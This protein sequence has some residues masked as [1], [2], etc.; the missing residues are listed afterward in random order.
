[1]YSITD[2]LRGNSISK[3]TFFQYLWGGGGHGRWFKWRKDD[4]FTFWRRSWGRPSCEYSSPPACASAWCTYEHVEMLHLARTQIILMGQLRNFPPLDIYFVASFV[5]SWATESHQ[6]VE[7]IR[8]EFKI[9]DF[10]SPRPA[11]K[12]SQTLLLSS[13]HTIVTSTRCCH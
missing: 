8:T 13:V 1:M 10:V 11:I 7:L 9:W 3:S 5:A 2:Q 6:T 12:L 4:L